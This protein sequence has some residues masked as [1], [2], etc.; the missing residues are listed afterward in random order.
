MKTLKSHN[1]QYVGSH[2]LRFKPLHR[3]ILIMHCR[4]TVI[5]SC[6]YFIR[7]S[8][9]LN[10]TPWERLA[11][12][13]VW[14]VNVLLCPSQ[15]FLS[16]VL[17]R[18]KMEREVWG[19]QIQ[20]LLQLLFHSMVILTLF[21]NAANPAQSLPDITASLE[22][23]EKINGIWDEEMYVQSSTPRLKAGR[24]LNIYT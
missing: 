22:H 1:Q 15:L 23:Y 13:L 6:Q 21:A 17:I 24:E 7:M 8:T 9:Q 19:S 5:V 20:E 4:Q 11:W 3:A 18:V 2:S 12:I 16:C 14:C 10:Y